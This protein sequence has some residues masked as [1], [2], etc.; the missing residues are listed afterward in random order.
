VSFYCG[1]LFKCFCLFS[2]PQFS[3]SSEMQKLNT[4]CVRLSWQPPTYPNG[5]IVKYEVMYLCFGGELQRSVRL[6]SVLRFEWNGYIG[7]E[8]LTG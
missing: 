7:L 3:P 8:S 1:V 2:V 4:T 5:R 6:L